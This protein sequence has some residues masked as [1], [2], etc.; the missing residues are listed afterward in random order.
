ME[1]HNKK[2]SESKLNLKALILGCCSTAVK[3]GHRSFGKHSFGNFYVNPH[4]DV[5]L[6]FKNKNGHR[7]KK[8][9]RDV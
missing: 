7:I 6:F 9:I 4:T 1:S 5:T 3:G 8:T 2:N